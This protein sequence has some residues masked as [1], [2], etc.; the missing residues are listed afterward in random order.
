LQFFSG[1]S[2]I[3]RW[4]FQIYPSQSTIVISEFSLGSA[5]LQN[6]FQV[7][8][9]LLLKQKVICYMKHLTTHNTWEIISSKRERTYQDSWSNVCR[10]QGF[11]KC[12]HETLWRYK[13][14]YRAIAKAF[15][16][17]LM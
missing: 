10:I 1:C 6:P 2:S 7:S 16:G 8:V 5:I 9:C 12:M 13:N 17:F 11:F 15:T 14:W 4:H 3:S